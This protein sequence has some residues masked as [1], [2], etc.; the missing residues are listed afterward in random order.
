MRWKARTEAFAMRLHLPPA[1]AL[2]PLSTAECPA[3]DGYG[4]FYGGDDE[5]PHAHR[6]LGVRRHG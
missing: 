5:R 4:Y 3:C 6:V 2:S 1:P